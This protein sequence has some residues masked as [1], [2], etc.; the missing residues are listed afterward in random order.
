MLPAPDDEDDDDD[1]VDDDD[2]ACCVEFL[3]MLIVDADGG[4]NINLLVIGSARFFRYSIIDT[5]DGIAK[6]VLRFDLYMCFVVKMKII[7]IHSF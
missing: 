2:A 3:R 4:A 5:F 7:C 1:G 6:L